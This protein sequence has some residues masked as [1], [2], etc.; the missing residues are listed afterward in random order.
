MKK[1]DWTSLGIMILFV[2]HRIGES[3]AVA[4]LKWVESAN[5]H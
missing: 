5:C 2:K 1:I 4:Y 3:Q